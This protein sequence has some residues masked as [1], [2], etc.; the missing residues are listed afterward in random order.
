[1]EGD[2]ELYAP[3]SFVPRKDPEKRIE[4]SQKWADL[5][6]DLVIDG[7]S[8]RTI[9]LA[10]DMPSR[11]AVMKWLIDHEDFAHQYARAREAQQDTYAEEIIHIAD[12]EKDSNKARVMI[13][14]RKWHAGKL[15]PKKY[16]DKV[17]HEH[18]GRVDADITHHGEIAVSA[19]SAFIAEALGAREDAASQ[20]PGEV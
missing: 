6:C 12:T 8:L 14:A 19:T 15:A 4:Y 11:S 16:G 5:I 3:S 7:K 9:C 17:E 13:D 20:E 10:D 18:S 1:M 2:F